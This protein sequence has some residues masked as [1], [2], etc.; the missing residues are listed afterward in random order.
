MSAFHV[1]ARSKNIFSA[2][3]KLLI[4]IYLKNKI[5]LSRTYFRNK[6]FGKHF[7]F[8]PPPSYTRLIITLLFSQSVRRKS[9]LSKI[10]DMKKKNFF[11]FNEYVWMVTNINLLYLIFFVK[12]PNCKLCTNKM[13]VNIYWQ[14][15]T[16]IP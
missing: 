9:L 14:Q 12:R 5:S 6:K 15:F 8:F 1:L 10:K 2:A 11:L 4:L 7:L 16:H 13:W 3:S